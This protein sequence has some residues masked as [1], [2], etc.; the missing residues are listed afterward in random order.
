MDRIS[1]EFGTPASA[2]L[3]AAAARGLQLSGYSEVPVTTAQGLGAMMQSGMEA[4]QA[5]KAAET[6]EK[7][8]KVQD[9][10]AMLTIKQ[11]MGKPSDL[12]KLFDEKN[13]QG[14]QRQISA[15]PSSSRRFWVCQSWWCEN[16]HKK[17]G[18]NFH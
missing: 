11:K 13:W 12:V 16:W 10:I 2:G 15:R 9:E 8:A 3:G 14:I 17:S 18:N 1:P 6:A 5:A 7:R 4:F